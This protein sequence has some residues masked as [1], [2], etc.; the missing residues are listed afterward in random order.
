[1]FSQNSKKD[2]EN[3]RIE[4]EVMQSASSWLTPDPNAWLTAE[5]DPVAGWKFWDSLLKFTVKWHK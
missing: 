3:W 5:T 2:L 4:V 1:M